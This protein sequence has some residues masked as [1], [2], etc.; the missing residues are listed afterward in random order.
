MGVGA[1]GPPIRRGLLDIEK[2]GNDDR[3]EGRALSFDLAAHAGQDPEGA[4]G[5]QDDA[6]GQGQRAGI[7]LEVVDGVIDGRVMIACSM[8]SRAAMFPERMIG[9]CKYLPMT[10]WLTTSSSARLSFH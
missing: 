4:I 2:A 5:S 6:V 10:C 8:P 3:I 7:E 9:F 1:A